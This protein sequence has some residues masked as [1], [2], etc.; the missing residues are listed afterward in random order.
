M[1]GLVKSQGRLGISSYR[2]QIKGRHSQ[3]EL[4]ARQGK[5]GNLGKEDVYPR[6]YGESRV[7]TQIVKVYT[8]N[9]WGGHIDALIS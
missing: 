5:E 9:V 3:Q 8:I 6:T 7:G 4:G 2:S 1:M